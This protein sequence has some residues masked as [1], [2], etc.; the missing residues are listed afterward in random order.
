MMY[1]IHRGH[2]STY[3][4]GCNRLVYLGTSVEQLLAAGCSVLLTDRNAVLRYA[5]FHDASGAEPDEGF[6]DW[7]LMQAT[8]WYDTP[9]HPDRR[10]RR[11]AECLVHQAVPWPAIQLIATRS[12]DVANEVK[13]R[14]ADA[15]CAVR[16]A[17]KRDWYF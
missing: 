1:S 12:V 5:T 14:L 10:E 17:V 15:G 11:M 9:Q 6:I 8:Y 4:D 3:T 2:V 7:D 13:E 16:V